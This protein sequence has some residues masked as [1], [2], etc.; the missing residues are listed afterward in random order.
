MYLTEKYFSFFST[1]TY[2]VGT[3]KNCLNETVLLST[4][5]RL[6]FR[7]LGKKII[8]FLRSKYLL[9]WNYEEEETCR[10]Q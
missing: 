5:N 8:A 7:L 9:N 1:K 10:D 4:Q 2:V 3:Q 6:M